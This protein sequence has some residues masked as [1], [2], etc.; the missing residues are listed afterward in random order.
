MEVSIPVAAVKQADVLEVVIV[1]IGVV[2]LLEGR[3]SNAA[4]RERQ[5][6]QSGAEGCLRHDRATTG[7]PTDYQIVDAGADWRGV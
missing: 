5:G 1:T 4:C 3:G 2:A 6:R 7:F